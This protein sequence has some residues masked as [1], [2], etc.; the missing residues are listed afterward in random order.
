M[1]VAERRRDRIW[2]WLYS[3]GVVL[4]ANCRGVL[5]PPVLEELGFDRASSA[6]T[7]AR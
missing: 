4:T 3:K 1:T 6:S 7:S 5:A 2:D